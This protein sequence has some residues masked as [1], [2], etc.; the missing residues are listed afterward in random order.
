MSQYTLLEGTNQLIRKHPEQ[1]ERLFRKH[2][3]NIRHPHYRDYYN[4]LRTGGMSF[5]DD[6]G[7]LLGGLFGKVAS[8]G[9]LNTGSSTM[10][11]TPRTPALSYGTSD[12]VSS[13]SLTETIP[14][15]SFT[16]DESNFAGPNNGYRVRAYH[17]LLAHLDMMARRARDPRFGYP[18]VYLPFPFT[19]PTQLQLPAADPGPEPAPVQE[20]FVSRHKK[21]LIGLAIALVI[22]LYIKFRK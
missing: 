2:G 17:E 15:T 1:G 10:L 9:A 4:G 22:V 18:A 14:G 7:S 19:V 11:S 12:G 20:S 3:Y 13:R 5:F 21:L 8:T 6:L 16:G